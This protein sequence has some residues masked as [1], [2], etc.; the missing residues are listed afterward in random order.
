VLG[1]YSAL[2]RGPAAAGACAEGVAGALETR[3]TLPAPAAVALTLCC[4]SA[5]LL[6]LRPGPALLLPPPE[7][8]KLC[9]LPV[10]PA[11][12]LLRPAVGAA[13]G[14]L[15]AGLRLRPKPTAAADKGARGAGLQ[16]GLLRGVAGLLRMG[17]EGARYRG[18]TLG[19]CLQSS[20]SASSESG[21]SRSQSTA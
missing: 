20:N 11:P 17:E 4:C 15:P 16:E 2:L 19:D 6:L 18:S 10:A 13:A 9:L 8:D 14:A 1:P 5:W 3:L 12:A 7:N 21:V